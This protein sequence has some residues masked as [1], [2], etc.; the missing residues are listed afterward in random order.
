MPMEDLF[1]GGGGGEGS[2]GGPTV[3]ST[4][5]TARD[6]QHTVDSKQYSVQSVQYTVHSTRGPFKGLNRQIVADFFR[7]FQTFSG[8][9]HPGRLDSRSLGQT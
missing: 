2:S 8:D 7:S 6:A 9:F 5:Y 1:V 4:Q 3:Q